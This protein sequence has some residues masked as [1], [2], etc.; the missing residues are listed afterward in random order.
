VV[1]SYGWYMRQYIKE[2]KAK[3]AIPIVCSLVARNMWENG[4][5]LR[6]TNDYTLWA[7]QAAE[8]EG[9][10]FMDLNN[11]VAT[12][13]E[14][15]GQ[16]YVTSKLFLTDH[17]HTNHEGAILNA[18]YVVEGLKTLKKCPLNKYVKKGK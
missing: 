14:E 9:A 1:Y 15:F 17:T 2:A 18:S 3:G 8:Q 7:S 16:E 4:K 6:A 10:F 12:H 11:I 5:V 13:Y